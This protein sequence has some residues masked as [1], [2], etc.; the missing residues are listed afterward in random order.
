MTDDVT[1]YELVGGWSGESMVPHP[2]GDYVLADDY[3]ALARRFDALAETAT[4]HFEVCV[5]LQN[6][7]ARQ[8]AQL[9][10]E[11]TT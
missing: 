2:S 11:T 4:E 6:R 7:L 8:L 10:P 1:R 9:A 3:D 5:L